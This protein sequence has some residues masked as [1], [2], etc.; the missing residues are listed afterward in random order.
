MEK[1]MIM[2]CA[3]VIISSLTP[4]EIERIKAYEPKSLTLTRDRDEPFT[5]DIDAGPGCIT[6][7]NAVYSRVKSTN[8]K[9]TITILL[10]PKTEDRTKAVSNEIGASLLKLDELEK[11]LL[12]R[13]ECVKGME[14]TVL[15][16]I[17][18]E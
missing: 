8:G 14:N 11:Q 15:S 3:C 2:G 6:K 13:N 17:S 4:E 18:R 16:M 12:T 10:D 5:I 1:V 9:A 7:E